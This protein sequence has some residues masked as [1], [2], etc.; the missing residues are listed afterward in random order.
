MTKFMNKTP[1][2]L[3]VLLAPKANSYLADLKPN[4][5][6][7]AYLKP[8][9]KLMNKTPNWLH[10][11]LVSKAKSYLA[12]IKPILAN[13]AYLKPITKF[14]SRTPNW[15]HVSNYEVLILVSN[16]C[17]CCHMEP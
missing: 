13:L 1:N 2:W 10:V 17:Q 7:L 3:Y 14:I 15:L 12:N 9:I 8:I 4:L 6:N 11:L 16:F 5:C